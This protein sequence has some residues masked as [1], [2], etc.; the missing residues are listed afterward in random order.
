MINLTEEQIERSCERA[1][2]MLNEQL[3]NGSMSQEQYNIEV[4]ALDDWAEEEYKKIKNN[5]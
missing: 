1:M 2:N 4:I 5:Y 3:M